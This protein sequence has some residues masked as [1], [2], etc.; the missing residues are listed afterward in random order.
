MISSSPDLLVLLD[1]FVMISKVRV[2]R[3]LFVEMYCQLSVADAPLAGISIC[4]KGYFTDL[5]TGLVMN[6]V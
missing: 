5:F 3:A 4:I 2:D 1:D 6:W